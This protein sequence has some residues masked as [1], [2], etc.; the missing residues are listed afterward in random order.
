MRYHPGLDYAAAELI[1]ASLFML[2]AVLYYSLHDARVE[3]ERKRM[4]KNRDD[5]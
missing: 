4:L 1:V 2:G 5:K 3:R